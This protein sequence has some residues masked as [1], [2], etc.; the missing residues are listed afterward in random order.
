[1]GSQMMSSQYTASSQPAHSVEA[2]VLA[3][4]LQRNNW[5]L[6]APVIPR[7]PRAISFSDN[8]MPEAENVSELASPEPNDDPNGHQHI[9]GHM[10]FNNN[11][12]GGK[13]GSRSRDVE[14]EAMRADHLPGST[15]EPDIDA[16]Y[17]PGQGGADERL[18]YSLA[19]QLRHNTG[20]SPHHH[21]NNNNVI[22]LDGNGQGTASQRSSPGAAS[23]LTTTRSDYPNG[24]CTPSGGDD[25]TRDR[26]PSTIS[27]GSSNP[28]TS[29]VTIHHGHGNGGNGGAPQS[30]PQHRHYVAGTHQGIIVEPYIAQP[31]L[32]AVKPLTIVATH[33]GSIRM[34]DTGKHHDDN[35]LTVP[36]SVPV[37]PTSQSVMNIPTPMSHVSIASPA[38][39]SSISTARG[40]GTAAVAWPMS[41]DSM[42]ELR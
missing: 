17:H 14:M 20:N 36:P 29:H 35:G 27:N 8:S 6:G 4:S 19:N 2:R 42:D 25:E 34:I 21:N 15:P 40:N 22:P 37:T 18:H 12:N 3:M 5:A 10:M 28:S 31:P 13:S 23:N 7:N 39:P 33:G 24:G 41:S 38:A 1:M 30:S 11:N 26:T 16:I 32:A 9:T